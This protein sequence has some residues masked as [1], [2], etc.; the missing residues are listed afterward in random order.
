MSTNIPQVAINDIGDEQAFLE[1]VDKTIKVSNDISAK[2]PSAKAVKV[3]Y[4]GTI[5]S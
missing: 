4:Q 2:E 3:N 1:A 5:L